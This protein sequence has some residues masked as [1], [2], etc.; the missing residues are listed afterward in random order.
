MD[1]N[2]ETKTNKIESWS[3]SYT[4]LGVMMG[5]YYALIHLD[6]LKIRPDLANKRFHQWY[7]NYLSKFYD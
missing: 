6:L 4:R 2:E 1:N 7:Q 5:F 3:Y